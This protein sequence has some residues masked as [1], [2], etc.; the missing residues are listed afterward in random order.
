MRNTGMKNPITG[1]ITATRKSA[2][3]LSIEKRRVSRPFAGGTRHF[4]VRFWVPAGPA[5]L[6]PTC[7]ARRAS[8]PPRLTRPA[9]AFKI[10][11]IYSEAITCKENGF[12][13]F[14]LARTKGGPPCVRALRAIKI[15]C[16]RRRYSFFSWRRFFCRSSTRRLTSATAARGRA[17]PSARGWSPACKQRGWQGLPSPEGS[18]FPRGRFCAPRRRFCGAAP[19]YSPRRPFCR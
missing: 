13:R 19:P 6:L 9:A 11:A 2:G 3:A 1:S 5:P 15:K 14:C 7:Q 10:R 16:W 8:G 18:V 4:S 12:R 17:A